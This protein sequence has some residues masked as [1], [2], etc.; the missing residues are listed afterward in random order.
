MHVHEMYMC[1]ALNFV[2]FFNKIYL[3]IYAC[4]K[5]SQT[6][7]YGPSTFS[8]IFMFFKMVQLFDYFTTNRRQKI[9]Q[10]ASNAFLKLDHRST[11][12]SFCLFVNLSLSICQFFT[13]I[14]YYIVDEWILFA[15]WTVKIYFGIQLFVQLNWNH[16]CN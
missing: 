1:E 9:L 10:S 8:K 14:L 12:L 2:L 5:N 7:W 3:F 11:H 13:S 4:T 16:Y 15:M 6:S